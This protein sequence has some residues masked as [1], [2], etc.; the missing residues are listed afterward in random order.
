MDDYRNSG[1]I[2]YN[3]S[4]RSV[5]TATLGLFA[6]ARFRQVAEGRDVKIRLV[7][8]AVSAGPA[9]RGSFLTSYLIDDTVAVDAGGLGFLGDVETQ[10][11]VQHVFL[12]HSHMDHIASLP[13]F[14]ETVFGS[15]DRCV[16]VHA[17]AETLESLRSDVFNGRIWPDFF[18]LSE[19]GVPFV[20]LDV[21]QPG[22]PVEA[23]GLRLTPVPVDHV[24]P[25]LGF[26]VEARG[27]AVAITSDTG[28]TDGFWRAA[29]AVADLRAVFIEATFPEEMSD[30]ADISKH[31]TPSL[32]ATEA[33]KL[34]RKVPLI[35][36]HIKPRFYDEVVKE[37]TAL[38]LPDLQ[39][40]KSGDHYVF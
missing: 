9:G 38:Q 23:G 15:S 21:L 17:S 28:P 8:S 35:A 27:T 31:L 24:V 19:Q 30:L 16:T 6:V 1:F 34:T 33:R 11:L 13:I 3:Q 2:L 40:G 14:L 39:I 32:L 10:A 37:L 7:P 12:S 18:A 5:S 29:D 26:L 25:T 36:V 4:K 20:K 22:R